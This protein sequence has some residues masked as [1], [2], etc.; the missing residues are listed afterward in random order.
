MR[1]SKVA[2]DSLDFA[3]ISELNQLLRSRQI[4]ARELARHFLDRLKS[5]GPQYNALA[6]PLDKLAKKDAK[7]VDGDLKRRTFS[8]PA[9]RNSLRRKRSV[10]RPQLSD[11]LGRETV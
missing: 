9:A 6:L 1:N 8:R 7:A 3:T 5:I 4:S 10:E 11:N 2:S